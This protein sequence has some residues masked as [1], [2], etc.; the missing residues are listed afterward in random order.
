MARRTDEDK[1]KDIAAYIERHPGSKP[2]E[3]ARAL[4]L[5]RSSITRALPALEDTRHL[6]SEDRRGGLWPFRR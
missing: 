2:A 6:F 1:V 5:P 3:I 4:D